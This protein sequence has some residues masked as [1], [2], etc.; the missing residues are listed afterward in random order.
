MK[1]AVLERVAL[2][3]QQAVVEPTDSNDAELRSQQLLVPSRDVGYSSICAGKE[4][5]GWEEGQR[6]Q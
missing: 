2:E 6:R 5:A 3:R 4:A 1:Q